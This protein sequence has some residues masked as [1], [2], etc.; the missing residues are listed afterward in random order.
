MEQSI[1]KTIRRL[2]GP[3]ATY[4]HF[5]HD[6]IT[7]INSEFNILD[8]LGIGP[9]DGFFI[10]DD[11]AT[12]DEYLQDQKT[13]KAVQ[14]YIYLKVRKVF[15]PPANSFLVDAIDKEIKELEWRLEVMASGN[16]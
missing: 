5:D 13:L 3:N 14:Q 2:L 8:Q 1:L 6:L 7:H 15:D 11:T 4:D 12:W 16:S 9:E 10:T